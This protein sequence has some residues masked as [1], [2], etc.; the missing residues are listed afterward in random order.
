MLSL[1][2]TGDLAFSKYFKNSYAKEDLLDT[3]IVKYLQDTDYVVANVEAPVTDGGITSKNSLVHVNS[4]ECIQTLKNI[5]ATVWTLANNHTMDCGVE[6]LK[7]T[8]RYAKENGIHTVGAGLNKYEA[9]RPLILEKDGLKVGILSVTYRWSVIATEDKPGCLCMEDYDEIKKQIRDKPVHD[10]TL[11]CHFC[12]NNST[13]TKKV[14]KI[15][16]KA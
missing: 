16:Q 2:F 14:L 9:S 7:D 6:G 1:A 4:P 11:F 15:S 8:L 5:N 3:N 13:K 10:S 12:Q